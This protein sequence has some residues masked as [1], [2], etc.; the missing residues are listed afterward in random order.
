MKIKLSELR[1]IVKSIINEQAAAQ[2]SPEA[3]AMTAE[4]AKMKNVPVRWY[5]E[6]ANTSQYG[7]MMVKDIFPMANKIKIVG[8]FES[9]DKDS[10][11]FY[12]CGK[13]NFTYMQYPLYNKK[14]VE[15]LK[16]LVCTKSAGGTDVINIGDYSS[17]T[18]NA[19][20]NVAESK[21]KLTNVIRQVVREQMTGYAGGTYT[22]GKGADDAFKNAG[23][24]GSSVSKGGA[25]IL[26]DDVFAKILPC[27]EDFG[28]KGVE[29]LQKNYPNVFKIVNKMF[30]DVMMGK[31]PQPANIVDAGLAFTEVVSKGIDLNN[32][33]AL[34]QVFTCI[35]GKMKVLNE[36]RYYK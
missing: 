27:L 36:R 31:T 5:N 35:L 18:S 13:S 24:S 9:F 34:M 16:S 11:I 12:E 30:S 33:A 14:Y 26:P 2:P 15:K 8:R 6:E 19:P 23:K 22:L 10:E 20:V 32:V 3:Q 7:V 28:V 29:D 1:Q 4:L 25:S 21:R 17:T